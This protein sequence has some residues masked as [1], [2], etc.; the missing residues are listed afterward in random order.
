MCISELSKVKKNDWLDF[1]FPVR[2][3]LIGHSGSLLNDP[4]KSNKTR[5]RPSLSLDLLL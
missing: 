4:L 3:N 1:F 2:R 5:L